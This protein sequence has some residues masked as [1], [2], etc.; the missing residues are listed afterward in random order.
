MGRAS[1]I[2]RDEL[3]FSKFISRLRIKFS[4]LFYILLEKQLLLKGTMTKQ[5]WNE[6]KDK[7]YFDFLEDNHFAELKEAEIMENRLRLLGD[8]DQHLGKYYS[9]AWIRKTIL[10]QTEDEI[11]DIDKEI[12]DESES[13]DENDESED[14][15][16]SKQL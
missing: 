11:E 13:D 6:I 8:V 16:E 4:E 1:E 14:E 9:S 15:F 7:I 2:T 3:K 10:R 12:E 5:E